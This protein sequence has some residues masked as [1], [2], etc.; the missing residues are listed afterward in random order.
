M[1]KRNRSARTGMRA[2]IH[3]R[4]IERLIYFVRGQPVMLDSDLA[5]LYG[6]TTFNLNKAVRRNPGRF[7]E[8]F[9]FQLTRQEWQ[10]LTF[11]IGIS[12]KGRGGRRHMPLVFTEH[13]A[14]ALSGVLRSDRA[15]EMF[16]HVIRAFVRM[17]HYFA[18]HHELAKQLAEL[19]KRV[20]TH[21]K[22]ITAIIEAIRQLMRPPEKPRRKIG[23]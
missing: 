7:P 22:Q 13:G 10:S 5:K 14:S 1:L 4:S 15:D 18:H 9:V 8:D 16:V 20:G 23:Y 17:K 2:L 19:E 11:Q 3:A 12:N 6:V 21:D